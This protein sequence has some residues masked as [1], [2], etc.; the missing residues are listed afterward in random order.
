M[1]KLTVVTPEKRI[2]TDQ[3]VSEV[4]LPG[5]RGE[6]NIL[7]G[8]APMI[9]I[10]ETGALKWKFAGSEVVHRA[11]VSGGY[12]QVS[13]EGVNVLANVAD[14]PE[15]VDPAA[16]AQF[17]SDADKKLL[18]E[19]LSELEFTELLNEMNRA[20]ADI[21]MVQHPKM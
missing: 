7:P 9:T 5:Y 17:L 20:R 8:H 6:L 10:L 4:T 13:P 2:V 12:C 19:T 3:E 21:E 14:L 16:K 11:V 18:N 1:F 15:E